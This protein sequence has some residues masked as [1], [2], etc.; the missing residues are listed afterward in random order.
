MVKTISVSIQL[1][2]SILLID[3]TSSVC[4]CRTC[5]LIKPCNYINDELYFGGDQDIDLFELFKIINKNLTK[6][7][8]HFKIFYL[9]NT[10]ITEL[11]ENIFIDITFDIIDNNFIPKYRLDNNI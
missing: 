2:A 3:T 11:N 9:N 8:K 10:F 5:D 7:G 4:P 6:T 1:F